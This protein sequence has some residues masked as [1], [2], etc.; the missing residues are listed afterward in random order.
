MNDDQS[1]NR[2]YRAGAAYVFVREGTTWSQQA[3]LKA[4]NTGQGDFVGSSIAVYVFARSGTT[5]SQQANGVT[6]FVHKLQREQLEC[7]GA[8]GTHASG[9][10]RHF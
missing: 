10:Q 4:S 9:G 8:A 3:Y 1:D 2:I 5:C 7:V 6:V